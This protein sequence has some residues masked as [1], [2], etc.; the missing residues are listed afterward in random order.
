MND[1]QQKSCHPRFFSN[2]P[3][4]VFFIF[5]VFAW[6]IRKAFFFVLFM[7]IIYLFWLAVPCFILFLKRSLLFQVTRQNLKKQWQTMQQPGDALTQWDTGKNKS[8]KGLELTTLDYQ[9]NIAYWINAV[10]QIFQEI[11]KLIPY[12]LKFWLRQV[13]WDEFWYIS[14]DS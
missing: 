10:L 5:R 14:L 13:E 2:L 12:V 8:I 4:S 9:I 1:P 6:N 7:I 11:N 3:K